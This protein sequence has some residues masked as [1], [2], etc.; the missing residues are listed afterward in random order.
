MITVVKV[1]GSLYDLADLGPRLRCWLDALDTGRIVLVP[2]G[3]ASA[4]VVRAWDRAQGLGEERAHWL[5]LQALT[6]NAHFLAGLLATRVIEGL[7]DVDGPARLIVLDPGAFARAD[8]GRLGALPHT[9]DVTSDSIAARVALVFGAARLCLLKS[10]SLPPDISWA[11]A[12]RRGLVDKHFPNVLGAAA[13][14]VNFVN[15]RDLP[16]T[17]K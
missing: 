15:L 10:V 2:G 14:D 1:G 3:G 8:E 5:A 16:A 4:D 7:G 6:L 11:E 12:A 17:W 9:W 13:L